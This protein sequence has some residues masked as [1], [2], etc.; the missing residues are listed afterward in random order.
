MSLKLC[1]KQHS[2]SRTGVPGAN[3]LVQIALQQQAGGAPG[4]NQQLNQI[5][6]QVANG[7]GAQQTQIL[8]TL[9]QIALQIS[10][11]EGGGKDKV[12]QTI[13]VIDDDVSKNH[14][15]RGSRAIERVT[16]C[17]FSNCPQYDNPEFN[18]YNLGPSII[19]TG[20]P[21]N[22]LGDAAVQVAVGSPGAVQQ[23]D[24]ITEQV[25]LETGGDPAQVKG[26]VQNLALTNSIKG[27]N[28]QEL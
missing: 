15:G 22:I 23:L 4:I 18:I 12:Q 26:V 7:T 1:N 2:R 3:A 25:S 24:Q 20:D 6:Q 8:Q 9:Q 27:G 19:Q 13:R 16:I 11:T 14:K 10:N 28:T 5:A 21:I 17:Y